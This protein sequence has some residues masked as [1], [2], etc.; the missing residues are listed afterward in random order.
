MDQRVKVNAVK[1]LIR[2]DEQQVVARPFHHGQIITGRNSDGVARF[3]L[4]ADPLDKVE[5]AGHLTRQFT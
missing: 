5:F 2:P 4:S 1:H 3:L